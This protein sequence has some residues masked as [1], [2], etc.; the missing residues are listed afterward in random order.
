MSYIFESSNQIKNRKFSSIIGSLKKFFFLFFL[1]STCCKNNIKQQ[2]TFR[3]RENQ[4]LHFM[5]ISLYK[6]S[7]Q[8]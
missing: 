3:V 4:Y 8:T 5:F 7:K 1:A 2:K 6:S